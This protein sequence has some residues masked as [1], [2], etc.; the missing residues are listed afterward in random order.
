MII[1]TTNKHDSGKS[2]L[3]PCIYH[4][5]GVS[6][7]EPMFE[8]IKKIESRIN[9][10]EESPK[11]HGITIFTW[12]VPE[13]TTLLEECFERMGIRDSLV[14]IPIEVKPFNWL[15]KI[16]KMNEYM[17]YVNTPYVMAL[18]ATD[19]IVSTD[20]R[21]SLWPNLIEVFE[22]MNCNML[23]NAEKNSWPSNTDMLN[24][25]EQLGHIENFERKLYLDHFSSGYCHG[26][27]GGFIGKTDY[28]KGFYERL[29][30]TTEPY[31][32]R[33]TNEMLFGGDQGFVRIAHLEEFPSMRYDYECRIFQTFNRIN[34]GE[35]NIYE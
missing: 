11:K 4:G 34:E 5:N 24:L 31:Y 20:V 12:S 14:V 9:Y 27:S 21:G 26:N 28:V 13:E 29:W 30:K 2:N 33:G 25:K 10:Q 17:P 3:W 19:V 35:I 7:N 16:K 8:K 6:K 22:G 15:D 23:W 18:D 1:E 32:D